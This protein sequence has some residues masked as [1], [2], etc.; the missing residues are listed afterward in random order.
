MGSGMARFL[1]QELHHGPPLPGALGFPA[2]LTD[3]ASGGRGPAFGRVGDL[4]P[5]VGAGGGMVRSDI[6]L[7]LGQPSLYGGERLC[8]HPPIGGRVP[9]VIGP[10]SWRLNMPVWKSAEKIKNRSFVKAH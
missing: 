6:G 9:M 2:H 4:G 5:A 7:L 1:R 10:A 8:G 3:D